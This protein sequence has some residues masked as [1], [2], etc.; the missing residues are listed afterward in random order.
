MDRVQH[1]IR[2]GTS[3]LPVGTPS[4]PVLAF[5]TGTPRYRAFLEALFQGLADYEARKGVQHHGATPL[6]AA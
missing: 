1:A 4:Y 2:L 5:G 3:P 6:P